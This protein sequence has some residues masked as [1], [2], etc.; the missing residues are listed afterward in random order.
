[1]AASVYVGRSI[2]K[3]HGADRRGYPVAPVLKDRPRADLLF[4]H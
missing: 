2:V 4:D 1:M 3:Q